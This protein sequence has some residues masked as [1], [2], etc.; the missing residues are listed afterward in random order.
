VIRTGNDSTAQ[1]E[2]SDGSVIKLSKFTQVTINPYE[3]EVRFYVGKLF[4]KFFKGEKPPKVKTPNAVA[5]ALGTAWVQE[6]TNEGTLI[7]VLEGHV[8]LNSG[9]ASQVVNAGQFAN[10]LTGQ[11]PQAP[12]TFSVNEYLK[13]EPIMENVDVQKLIQTPPPA[14]NPSGMSIPSVPV[15]PIPVAAVPIPAGI[16]VIPV[17]SSDNKEQTI[18]ALPSASEAAD[19]EEEKGTGTEDNA[20]VKVEILQTLD[21]IKYAILKRKTGDVKV[22]PSGSDEWEK[23]KAGQKYN[24]GDTIS[25]GE[26]SSALLELSNG[27]V[28]EISPSAKMVVKPTM[29]YKGKK[30]KANEKGKLKI[31]TSK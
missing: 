30:H 23:V 26:K 20:D 29:L 24:I 27:W 18:A 15:P 6:L 1:L 9:G 10:A 11:P 19:I 4:V 16:P 7:H 17:P 5:A 3:R 14:A 12:Q 22:L 31:T 2:L 8:D 28:V 25:T 21:N 13:A